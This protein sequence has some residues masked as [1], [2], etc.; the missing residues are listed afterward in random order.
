MAGLLQEA[1]AY[2]LFDGGNV[3]VR[4]RQLQHLFAR[5]DHDPLTPA[6]GRPPS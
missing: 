1:P 2:P 4:R 6:E 5:P 3:V